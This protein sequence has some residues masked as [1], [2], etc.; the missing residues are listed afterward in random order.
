MTAETSPGARLLLVDDD[1][2]LT[3]ALSRALEL[4]G[5]S[6]T[7][8]NDAGLALAS[9]DDEAPGI[10]V[11]DIMMP[12][13]DG[14]RLCRLIR[15]RS[16][17]PILMLTARDSVPDRVAGLEAG[18][19]D[20]LIKP[21]ATD[22]L[23]ARISALLRRTQP[24]QRAARRYAYADLVLD[25]SSW[26]VSRAGVPITLTTKEFR[27]LEA[28]MVSP[29]RVLTREDFL[30]AAWDDDA[31]AESNVVDVHM[32]S[33]RQKLKEGVRPRL[34]QTIRGIGYILKAET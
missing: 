11:L 21:F 27:M 8:A 19:D 32:A 9:L 30:A 18:A 12:G 17:V 33:L 1:A 6:V 29:E 22:E 26:Q 7:V 16:E 23:V 10:I 14:L 24:R 3:A 13:L 34:I 20:Y 28:M 31:F 25:S 4:R 2:R 15:S 5:F